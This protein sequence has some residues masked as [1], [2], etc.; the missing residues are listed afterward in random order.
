MVRIHVIRYLL[1]R[2]LDFDD[3]NV[4][5]KNVQSRGDCCHSTGGY[6]F[7]KDDVLF[8]IEC[9]NL[10]IISNLFSGRRAHPHVKYKSLNSGVRLNNEL[11]HQCRRLIHF[12]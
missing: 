6:I 5:R 9:S 3:A 10:M 2:E 1:F 4:T 7:P 8:D 12:I 11:Q